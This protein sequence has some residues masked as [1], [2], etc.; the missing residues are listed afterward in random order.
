MKMKEFVSINTY[1]NIIIGQLSNLTN[2]DIDKHIGDF[3]DRH[4][5]LTIIF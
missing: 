3:K 4:M 2:I 1:L 5:D